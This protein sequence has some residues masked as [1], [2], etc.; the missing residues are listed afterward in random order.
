MTKRISKGEAEAVVAKMHPTISD[1]SGETALSLAVLTQAV[2]DSLADQVI[3]P[4]DELFLDWFGIPNS[5]YVD[6]LLA[7]GCS[8]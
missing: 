1:G 4:V 2:R 5:V 3:Q 7:E 8:L 6:V